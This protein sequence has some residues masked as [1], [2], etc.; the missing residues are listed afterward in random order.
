MTPRSINVGY[1][2]RRD[3]ARRPDRDSALIVLVNPSSPQ[4]ARGIHRAAMRSPAGS[5]MPAAAGVASISA[6]NC[7]PHG[8]DQDDP[9]SYKGSAPALT[10]LTAATWLY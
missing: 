9:H 7:S 6:P 1:D 2:P 4:D 3:F 10:D 8:G 5:T